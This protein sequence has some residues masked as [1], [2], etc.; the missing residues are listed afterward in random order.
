MHKQIIDR[1]KTE[2]FSSLANLLVYDQAKLESFI[3]APFS[4]KNLSE[5]AEQK[6]AQFPKEQRRLL[7]EVLHEQMKGFNHDKVSESLFLLDDDS[8]VTITTGHQLNLYTGPLYVIYKIM[9]VIKLA[10]RMNQIDDNM[11]Y[12]PLFW[13][14]TEDHDFEE[15]NHLH[16]FNDTISWE[17][18]QSGP[19]GRFSLDD[20]EATKQSL[21]EKF[22]NNPSFASFLS[23]F[24]DKKESLAS[25]TRKF[26]MELFE[27]YG[28]IVLDAD[29]ERL[30]RSFSSI[31]TKEVLEHFSEPLVENKTRELEDK[32]YNGQV[33]PRPVNLF[34]ITNSQ[35]DRIIPEK[36]GFKIGEENYTQEEVLDLLENHPERFSPNVVLRPVYQEFI[37]PN[38]CY[39][40]G[41]GEMSYWLQLKDVFDTLEIPYPIIQVRNSVQFVDGIALKKMN[42]LDISVDQLFEDIHVLK[43]QYVLEHESSELE[44]DSFD[45]QGEDLSKTIIE[46]ITSVDK[47]LEGYG[48]SE[49]TRLQK[50]LDGIKQKLIRHQ[51]KKHDQAMDQIDNLFERLFPAGG[52]QERYDNIIPKLAK[53]GKDQV[54]KDLYNNMD[55]EEKG[56][57]LLIEE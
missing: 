25:A 43:K 27:E 17:T 24:Y 22:E 9:H 46:L 13:M 53:Y 55:P 50:Q 30:K 29:D 11:N 37:L 8:A 10:E 44:F 18:D 51:K 57:I 48:K 41:G 1:N 6:V 28:L 42:K 4:L 52:L 14:A 31:M 45:Q 21:L 56:L 5:Q 47:G 7:N 33:T 54:L 36:G 39:V 32:G 20:F 38:V 35:R 15:I 2:Y 16:L 12:V 40:G 34:Y 26:V 3:T 19:V 23:S 49:V